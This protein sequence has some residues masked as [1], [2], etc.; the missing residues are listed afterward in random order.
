MI[1]VLGIDPS[2]TA[3]AVASSIGWVEVTGLKGKRTDGYPER[4]TR[5]RGVHTHF[6]DY[7]RHDLVVIEGPSYRSTDPSAFD[8]A[9]L[10][11]L[12]YRTLASEEIPVAVVPPTLRAMYAT[13]KGN[14]GKGAVIDAVARRWPQFATNGDDNAADA[15]VL[16]AMGL[17]QI[18]QPLSPMPATHRRALERVTWPEIPGRD[19][20]TGRMIA[21]RTSAR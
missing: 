19:P 5:I 13:G 6:C 16:L 8:R 3:T 12:I 20:E 4:L 2:L 17:D 10:W 21:E 7:L 1:R 9:A 15:V 14:A 11:W 18:G